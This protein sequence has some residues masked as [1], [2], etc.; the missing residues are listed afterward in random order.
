LPGI[1]RF[2]YLAGYD[3]VKKTPGEAVEKSVVLDRRFG[4]REY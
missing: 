3:I 4:R 2:Y 1:Y